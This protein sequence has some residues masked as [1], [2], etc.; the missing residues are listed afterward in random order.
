[1][2]SKYCTVALNICESSV[3]N[4]F[5][6]ARNFEVVPRFVERF[7]TPCLSNSVHI[8]FQELAQ[9]WIFPLNQLNFLR[10]VV[11]SDL[12]LKRIVIPAGFEHM[13]LLCL[14]TMLFTQISCC[15]VTKLSITLF[16]FLPVVCG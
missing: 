1:M 16:C 14:L 5:P 7:F 15:T 13:T 12:C 10:N 6:G 9:T 2:A 4:W 8:L 11:T 3:W